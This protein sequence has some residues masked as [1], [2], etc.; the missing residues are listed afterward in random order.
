MIRT[1]PPYRLTAV[2]PYRR[3]ALPPYRPT[4]GFT[5]VE[6]LVALTLSGL[7]VLTVAR[8]FTTLV[9]AERTLSVE[10]RTR[11]RQENAHRWLVSAFLSLE[12]GAA[13]GES[14][15]GSAH[16]VAFTTWQMTP[17]GWF[18]RRRIVLSSEDARLQAR[19]DDGSTVTLADSLLGVGFDYLLEP[20]ATTHW[21]SSWISPVSAPLAVRIRIT[22]LDSGTTDT[23]LLL[24]KERG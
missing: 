22:P 14:F 4:A 1:H 10:R 3:T 16:Q 19:L 9:T 17:R 8:L 13:P 21:V 15:E 24:I 6:L 23:L 12:V 7:V 11:T 20:G 18:E 2:P 5:L